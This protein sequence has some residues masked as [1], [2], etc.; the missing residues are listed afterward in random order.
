MDCEEVDRFIDVYL[1]GELDPARWLEMEQHF[2]HCPSCQSLAKERQ[3]F[4]AFFKACAPTY[5]TPPQLRT[6]LS[7]K[8]RR[9]TP[10]RT[11]TL[12]RV[13][14]VYAAAVLVLGLFLA[15]N[16]LFHDSE[17]E[18]S[19]QA[20]LHHSRSL[21]GAHL[22]DVASDKPQVVKS[23]LTAK[24]AFSPPVVGSPTSGYSLIGARL[25]VIQN[26]LVAVLVYKHGKDVVTL[27]CWPPKKGHLS[28]GDHFIEGYHVYTW[29][30]VACNYVLVSKL[31][32]REMDEFEDSFRDDVQSGSNS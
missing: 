2:R 12:L 17:K 32:E 15:Q 7:A 22:L 26:R 25:D 8:L 28:N 10:K 18:L 27:F 14:W 3:E 11:F 16:I 24:L 9:Q 23:W 19:R 13:P 29:S 20:V 1:D 21:T 4:L 30:N 6:K 5:Q 31:S